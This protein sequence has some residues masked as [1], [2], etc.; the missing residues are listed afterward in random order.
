MPTTEASRLADPVNVALSVDG[1]ECMWPLLKRGREFESQ[2]RGYFM[3]GYSHNTCVCLLQDGRMSI[4]INIS[5][6]DCLGVWI[7]L[8]RFF[9]AAVREKQ[10]N[11]SVKSSGAVVEVCMW[12]P[13]G[14]RE[15]AR[16]LSFPLSTSIQKYLN[17]VNQLIGPPLTDPLPLPRTALS[18]I[19]KAGRIDLMGYY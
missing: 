16:R 11:L 3:V 17:E 6:F 4:S 9:C 15:G 12:L 7:C 5:I 13:R 10:N 14:S 2:K 8:P 1:D 18:E 19:R